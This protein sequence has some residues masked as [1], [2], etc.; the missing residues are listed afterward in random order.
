MAQRLF[1][2]A[3]GQSTCASP[4][5][6]SQVTVVLQSTSGFPAPLSFQQ[7]SAIILD[8]GNPAWDPDNPL[9]TPY[10]YVFCTGNNTGT[11][12]LTI[13]RGQEGTTGHAFSAGATVAGIMLPSDFTASFPQK[14]GENTL[15]GLS[16]TLG[17]FTIPSGWRSLRIKGNA[18]GNGAQVN[19]GV[20]FN[21]DTGNNYSYLH[22][23]SAGAGPNGP[24][25]T[26]GNNAVIAVASNGFSTSW[27]ASIPNYAGTV[28]VNKPVASTY[29]TQGF[30]GVLAGY[31][32]QSSAITSVSII[33]SGNCITGSFVEVFVDP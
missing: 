2:A 15:T 21:G 25:A 3:G 14:L 12:T 29:S 7:F 33:A 6:N 13:T 9:A 24:A 4:I 27:E 11:N 32:N 31:W 5:N 8:S 28:L 26:I 18:Q 23:F 22:I 16:T 17:T 1:M 20:Q 30:V 19:I 10:E